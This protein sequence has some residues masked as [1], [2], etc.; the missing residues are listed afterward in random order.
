MTTKA[1][2]SPSEPG[3]FGESRTDILACVLAGGQ[4]RRMGGGDKTLLEIGGQPMLDLI[5]AR[6][7]PQANGVVLNANGD[8]ARFANYGLPVVADPIEG[9]KGPLAGIL[10]GLLYAR[11]V[12]PGVTHV[13]S[14]ASDTPFFPRDLISRLTRHLPT[15]GP[16][17]ALACSRDRLHPVFGLWPVEL[18]ENLED[19]LRS[20]ETGKVLAWVDQHDSIEVHFEDD[21]DTGLDPFFNANHPDDLDLAR[22]ALGRGPNLSDQA[23]A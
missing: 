2:S 23:S 15:H 4:S 3:P 13:V 12:L 8:P 20:G 21:V 9:Y 11:D 6:L 1:S 18:A 7:E 19:W 22:S 5:L 10:A 14:V 17:I 16:V